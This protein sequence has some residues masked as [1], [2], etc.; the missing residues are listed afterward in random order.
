MKLIST[1]SAA[2]LIG[3]GAFLLVLNANA[4]SMG[5]FSLTASVLFLLGVVR[6]YSPRRPYWQL[7]PVAVVR[8][9]ATPAPV[10]QL[11]A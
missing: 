2:A 1:L 11:A 4:Q 10:H 5:L 8:F 6:D 9:P 7:S 3:L